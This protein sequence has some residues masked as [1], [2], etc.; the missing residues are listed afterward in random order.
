MVLPDWTFN[1][2]LFLHNMV[3]IVFVVEEYLKV[4]LNFTLEEAKKAQRES[5]GTLYSFFNHGAR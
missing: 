2:L 3:Y 4:K 1:L 5:T